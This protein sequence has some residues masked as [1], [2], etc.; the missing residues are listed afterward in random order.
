MIIGTGACLLYGISRVVIAENKNF[1]GGESY[2]RSRGVEVVVLDDKECT[3]LMDKFISEKPELWYAAHLATC[4]QNPATQT[5]PQ[6]TLILGT[7]TLVLRNG[8]GRRKASQR[9]QARTDI[10]KRNRDKKIR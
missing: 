9:T 2:L 10:H 1:V 4:T 3:V 8:S 7:R 5:L 6:L